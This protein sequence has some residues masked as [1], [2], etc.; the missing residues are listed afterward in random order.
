[1]VSINFFERFKYKKR[2]DCGVNILA[3][4]QLIFTNQNYRFLTVNA[5]IYIDLLN[6]KLNQNFTGPGATRLFP[7]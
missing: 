4:F 5:L 7:I 1:M 6:S 3:L 2:R